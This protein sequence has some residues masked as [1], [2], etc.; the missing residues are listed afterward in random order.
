MRKYIYIIALALLAI[1]AFTSC[2]TETKE[3]PGGTAIEKMCGYWD[4]V[5][6]AV[7]ANGNV[8]YEDVY[9]AGT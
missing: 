5:Y 3:E 4:V 9:N 1:P 6:D 2:D 7:D 8:L